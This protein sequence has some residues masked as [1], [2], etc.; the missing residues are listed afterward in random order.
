MKR[1]I[2]ILVVF[3]ILA[4]ASAISGVASFSTG[5]HGTSITYH[6]SLLS[7]VIAAG[8]GVCEM[9]LAWGIYRRFAP[10][11]HLTFIAMGLCWIYGTI[12]ASAA[13][14]ANYPHQSQRDSLLFTALLFLVTS[15]V[16][17][18]W[19]YRWYKQKQYFYG[20]RT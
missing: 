15:P 13:T 18:Y 1:L 17:F 19:A 9:L 20:E 4:I 12:C 2:I 8:F 10:V 11:W 3:G 16:V 6:S 7:R 5:I 14:A